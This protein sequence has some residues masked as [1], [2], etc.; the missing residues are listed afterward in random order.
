MPSLNGQHRVDSIPVES[1]DD[2]MNQSTGSACESVSPTGRVTRSSSRLKEVKTKDV[3]SSQNVKSSGLGKRKTMQQDPAP[4]SVEEA[5]Q[6]QG[7]KSEIFKTPRRNATLPTKFKGSEEKARNSAASVRTRANPKL[8]AVNVAPE[9]NEEEEV[10]GDAIRDFQMEDTVDTTLK[11]TCEV[12]HGDAN[13]KSGSLERNETVTNGN[14]GDPDVLL[15]TSNLI[16]EDEIAAKEA[17]SFG[18][19]VMP[20]TQT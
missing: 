5:E 4:S 11:S 20:F 8:P 17:N 9:T 2:V 14:L 12:Y 19:V 15:G 13:E 10:A 18:F 3:D 1:E 6:P 7:K 16:S